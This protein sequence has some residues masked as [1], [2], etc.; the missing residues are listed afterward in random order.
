MVRH[1]IFILILAASL[2]SYGCALL[3]GAG[4][5]GTVVGTR[6]AKEAKERAKGKKQ[7]PESTMQVRERQIRV[8]DTKY[9][10]VFKATMDTLQDLGFIIAETDK[11]T[12]L[13][14]AEMNVNTSASQWSL[15]LGAIARYR[16]E[17][18]ANLESWG[19]GKTR[20]R[21]NFVEEAINKSDKVVSSRAIDDPEQYRRFFMKLDKAVFIR[22]E[23][24]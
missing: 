8:Y 10:I 15:F 18:T 9:D 23:K 22:K 17:A 7:T 2:S 12:G 4:A 11:E 5:A 16:H 21:I 24:L 3:I 19:K 1:F 6:E 13:I 20:V 14:V